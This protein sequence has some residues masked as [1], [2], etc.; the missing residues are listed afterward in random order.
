MSDQ[1]EENPYASVDELGMD[2][3]PQTPVSPQSFSDTDSELL[4]YRFVIQ[5]CSSNKSTK[6]NKPWTSVLHGLHARNTLQALCS[7]PVGCH[8]RKRCNGGRIHL[9]PCTK[10]LS[11]FSFPSQ[12]LR[13]H[14]DRI[15]LQLENP[16]D[17][18]SVV[19]LQNGL[20]GAPT[21]RARGATRHLPGRLP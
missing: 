21:T 7:F 18:V 11:Q 9:W 4:N 19:L 15:C 5:F 14:A 12:E 20:P 13:V 10:I 3:E 17:S 1:G 16:C 6:T 8:P 2:T